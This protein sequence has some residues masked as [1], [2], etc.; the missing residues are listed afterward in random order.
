MWPITDIKAKHAFMIDKLQGFTD[1]KGFRSARL[2]SWFDTPTDYFEGQLKILRNA[3]PSL[4]VEQLS[5]GIQDNS[6]LKGQIVNDTNEPIKVFTDVPAAMTSLTD[7][8]FEIVSDP[9]QGQIFW[10]IGHDRSSN[11]AKAVE[12]NGYL[13][14]F[15]CDEVL[16]LKDMFVPLLHST[17]KCFVEQKDAE[18]SGEQEMLI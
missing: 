13:N 4:D 16:L 6:P 5:Q 15:P 8:R 10:L 14:E 11:K 3:M 12:K 18:A 7:A 2:H 9:E 1:Q 17:Y